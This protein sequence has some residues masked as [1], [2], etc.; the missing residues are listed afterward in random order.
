M[1]EYS[2]G[3]NTTIRGRGRKIK[4][5][6]TS[7]NWAVIRYLNELCNSIGWLTISSKSRELHISRTVVTKINWKGP[8]CNTGNANLGELP[9]IIWSLWLLLFQRRKINFLRNLKNLTQLQIHVSLVELGNWVRILRLS[10]AC[11]SLT[12]VRLLAVVRLPTTGIL[13]NYWQLLAYYVIILQKLIENRQKTRI[14]S[15]FIFIFYKL[16]SS[17][18]LKKQARSKVSKN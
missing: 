10:R 5:E 9:K 3:G 13:A 7:I 1:Q 15:T 16:K 17:F 4:I 12:V 18:C 6:S 11:Q 8:A 14:K 2:S